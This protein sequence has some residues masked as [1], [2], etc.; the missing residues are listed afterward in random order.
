M[1]SPVKAHMISSKI[2]CAGS[3]IPCKTHV[4]EMGGG[5]LLRPKMMWKKL[6]ENSCTEW[7]LVAFDPKEIRPPRL[8]TFYMLNSNEHE[9]SA[10]HKNYNTY[11]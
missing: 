7:K 10:A 9:I 3:F 8:I 4:V 2:S 5:G 11:K 1:F 6:T